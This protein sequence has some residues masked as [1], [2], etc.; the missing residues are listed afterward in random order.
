M[1]ANAPI[2]G[3]SRAP[4][5]NNARHVTWRRLWLVAM[6]T[7]MGGQLGKKGG[8]LSA[9]LNTM[10]WICHTVL[11]PYGQ[12]GTHRKRQQQQPKTTTATNY[13]CTLARHQRSHCVGLV[14]L[15]LLFSVVRPNLL[16]FVAFCSQKN[17]NGPGGHPC[18]V[19]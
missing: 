1:A 12:G 11:P 3:L 5:K 6:T 2:S 19:P 14:A 15:L 13:D 18:H 16:S 8:P 9:D 10:A 4:N 7:E 17:P